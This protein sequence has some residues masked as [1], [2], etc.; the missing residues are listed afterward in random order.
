MSIPAL[1]LLIASAVLHAFWNL[2]LKQSQEKY[3]AIGWQVILSGIFE[4]F[5]SLAISMV[6]K[7]YTPLPLKQRQQPH[8]Q[9]GNC[10]PRQHISHSYLFDLEQITDRQSQQND[11]AGGGQLIHHGGG[12]KGIQLS[13]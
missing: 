9:W 11:S 3:L 2:L 8:N 5:L 1:L 10:Q 7:S 13:G 12:H 4:F 6:R